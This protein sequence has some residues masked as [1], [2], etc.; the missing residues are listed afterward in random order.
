M[1]E[2]TNKA[3]QNTKQQASDSDTARVVEVSDQEFKTARTWRAVV[4]EV[5]TVQ[6]QMGSIQREMGWSKSLKNAGH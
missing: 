2:E 3:K 5:D 1:N 4:G 6:E